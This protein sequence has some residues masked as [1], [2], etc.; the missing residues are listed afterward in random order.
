[1]GTTVAGSTPTADVQSV[2]TSLR[3]E[4][5]YGLQVGF[6]TALAEEG[7]APSSAGG[8]GGAAPASALYEIV[9]GLAIAL[10]GMVA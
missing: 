6:C 8:P 4:A 3:D 1:M 10:A 9:A 2:C 5:C 7:G